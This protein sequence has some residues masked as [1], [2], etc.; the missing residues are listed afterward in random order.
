MPVKRK[1]MDSGKDSYGPGPVQYATVAGA[2]PSADTP[3]IQVTVVE[4][5]TEE[6][7]K[8]NCQVSLREGYKGYKYGRY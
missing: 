2:I 7:V 3:N 8:V 6:I 4:D 5:L 1:V